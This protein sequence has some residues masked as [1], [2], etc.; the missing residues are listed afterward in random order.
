MPPPNVMYPSGFEQDVSKQKGAFVEV[1]G[2]AHQ[3]EGKSRPTFFR[4]VATVV[5]KL[6]NIVQVGFVFGG[7]ATG[8][9]SR[10]LTRFLDTFSQQ[11]PSSDKKTSSKPSFSGKW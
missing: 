8:P 6:L 5:L 10:K 11:K 7:C 3:M 9:Q 4:G 2:F 1:Q